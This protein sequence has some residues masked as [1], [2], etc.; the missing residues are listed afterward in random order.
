M[1]LGYLQESFPDA[2]LIRLSCP[3]AVTHPY[4][5][6]FGTAHV[7]VDLPSV[8][9][10]VSQHGVYIREAQRVVRLDDRLGSGATPKKASTTTSSRTRVSPT[11]KTPG[12]SSLRGTVMGSIVVRWERG[13]PAMMKSR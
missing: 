4:G 11:R 5:L 8:S 9:Q 3:D 10:A 1:A 6:A 12:G 2:A 7:V 13:V